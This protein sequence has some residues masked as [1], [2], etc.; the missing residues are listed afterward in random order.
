VNHLARKKIVLVIVEGPSDETA[1]GVSLSRIFDKEQVYIHIMHGDITTRSGVTSSNIISKIGEEVKGYA[2]SRHYKVSDFKEIIHIID[3]DGV[4]IPNDNIIKG[5]ES[6]VRYEE[7]GIYTDNVE[8]IIARN[9]SKRENIYKLRTTGK[10]WSIPYSIYYMSCNLDH[11]LYNKRNS[12]DEEK[13]NDSYQFAIKY[14][15]DTEGFVNYICNSEF[16]VCGD[17]KETWKFI[18][19]DLNSLE[20]HTNF[21]LCIKL[22]TEKC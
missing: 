7:D 6:C 10:I 2:R 17:Y 20:R 9:N 11:V 22:N 19:H 21:G 4:Y 5:Q 8:V 18:E 3:T 16:A 13:E 15:N 12:T 14:K 1:L